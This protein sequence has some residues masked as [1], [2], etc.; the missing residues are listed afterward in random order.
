MDH[1][2]LFR[3]NDRRLVAIID[4]PVNT[5]P[6]QKNIP[7][8][9]VQSI[10]NQ[11]L[12][13]KVADKIYHRFLQLYGSKE[14]SLQQIAETP[15]TA[16][17][18]IGLSNAKAIYVHNV[19]EFCQSHEVTD[20]KLHGMSDE[21][22][23]EL[24]TQIKGVGQ[25]TVEILLVFSLGR[26]DVFVIDDYGIQEAMIKLYRIKVL[27]K[28]QLREKLTR[29]SDKW[30]PFRSYACLYLWQWRDEK[31]NRRVT[32]KSKTVRRSS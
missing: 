30:R 6:V 9:L 3:K 15:R 5:L 31:K 26:E 19:A 29:I 32:Q 20:K 12:N 8:T 2:S 7:L 21:D 4:K 18:A 25:W 1:L 13:S 28:K 22:V 11:Q 10:M 17:R 16:L 14:P 23:M 24:L 27:D